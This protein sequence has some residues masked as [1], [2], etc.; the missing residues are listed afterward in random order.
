MG[1]SAVWWLQWAQYW[2]GVAPPQLHFHPT[3]GL[4]PSSAG[5][6]LREI[7]GFLEIL[8]GTG[9]R[10]WAWPHPKPRTPSTPD[11]KWQLL[12][13]FRTFASWAV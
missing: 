2:G 1:G 10:T 13:L 11:K 6:A 9:R 4:E 8:V 3:L 7:W 12:L 5:L